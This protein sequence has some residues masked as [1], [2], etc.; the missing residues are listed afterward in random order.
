MLQFF[1]RETNTDNIILNI[2]RLLNNDEDFEKS[3]N[4]ALEELSRYIHPDR[5]YVLETDGITCSNTFEW[6]AP[7]V[8]PEIDTLQNLRYD[9]Y[10]GGWEKYLKKSSDVVISDI[11]ELKEDDLADYENLKRQGIHRLAA[12][13]F[14]NRGKLIGYLGAD[15]YEQNDLVN[16]Q[17]VL[18]SISYFIG[19]KIVNHRLMED[20]NR[21]SS[22]DTLTNVHNRNA[23]ILKMKELSEKHVPTG[24]VYAD[25]NSLKIVNDTQGHESGDTRR[26][27]W[28]PIS[29][30]KT[31]TAQAV[32]SLWSCFRWSTRRR[33]L[34]RRTRSRRTW[35]TGIRITFPSVCSGAPTAALSRDLFA[36]RISRCIRKRKSTTAERVSTEEGETPGSE[37]WKKENQILSKR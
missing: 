9:E 19:T 15:N 34:Q 3:M 16:T 8:Q 25:V 21:L 32:M 27:C 22:M 35:R 24:L 10:L 31:S 36:S 23:M 6:C 17:M 7:G 18:N 37:A 20:L 28:P 33:F 2:S 11:V 26:I 30:G 1:K 14:Y 5:L 4:H 12:A 13:P 29:G